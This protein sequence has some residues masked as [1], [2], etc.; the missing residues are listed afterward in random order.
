MADDISAPVITL[1]QPRPKKA[2]TGAERARASRARKKAR[3]LLAIQAVTPA[4][5]V[6]DCS[7]RADHE[8]AI[9]KILPTDTVT[10]LPA[11]R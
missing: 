2:E 4:A 3:A 10:P 5:P 8:G 9:S 11:T 1:H 7:T 6:E